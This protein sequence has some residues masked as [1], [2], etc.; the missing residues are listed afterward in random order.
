MVSI[1][2]ITGMDVFD[3]AAQQ[4][5]GDAPF[6]KAFPVFHAAIAIETIWQ[7]VADNLKRGLPEVDPHNPPYQHGEI[8]VIC[9][10][11]P[12]IKRKVDRLKALAADPRVR[13]IAIKGMWR[14]LIDNGIKPAFAMMMDPHHSQVKYVDG[15]P[16]WLPWYLS[17]QCDPRVFDTLKGRNVTIFNTKCHP[18]PPDLEHK[19]N[20]L[21]GTVATGSHAIA[22]ACGLGAREIHLFGIDCCMELDDE[23][24][25]IPGSNGAH[26]YELAR[27]EQRGTLIWP[28]ASAHRGKYWVTPVQGAEFQWISNF[29]IFRPEYRVF[30]HGEGMI[31]DG[32]RDMVSQVSQFLSTPKAGHDDHL[33]SAHLLRAGLV[34]DDGFDMSLIGLPI[35]TYPLPADLAPKNT[36]MTYSSSTLYDHIEIEE[37]REIPPGSVFLAGD[38][39]IPVE[40]SS[41]HDT[42]IEYADGA[43][44]T[45]IFKENRP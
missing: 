35:K 4:P 19:A 3:P 21:S 25:P 45:E 24:M 8:A 28:K 6:E 18:L 33:C 2:P 17:S 44:E 13:I 37:M 1:S 32:L 34:S 30:V 39:M 15:S 7:N 43:F 31:A 29:I 10:A 27:G 5:S 12:S 26:V 11:A 38:G 9:G 42:F 36:M 23:G 41:E 40:P 16:D 22:L 20:C 14:W